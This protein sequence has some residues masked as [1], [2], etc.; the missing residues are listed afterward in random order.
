MPAVLITPEAMLHQHQA[1][2]TRL[3]VE[4][5]L[6]VRYP[7]DPT[8]TRGRGEDETIRALGGISAVLAGA[9]RFTARVIDS[10]P[11]LRVIARAGVG[12]DRVDVAS[13]TARNVAITI[14]PTANHQAVAEQAMALMLALSRNVVIHDRITRQGG[15]QG[16]VNRPLRG[17]T[18]GLVGS[19]SNRPQHG[20]PR[21]GVRH[22]DHRLRPLCRSAFERR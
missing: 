14:T 16:P 5:G 12:Y 2:Y 20:R 15:W 8:F 11:D 10:L 4:A 1:D 6:E 18:L 21:A 13:A 22:E 3:L 17:A 7:D 9:D 19:G